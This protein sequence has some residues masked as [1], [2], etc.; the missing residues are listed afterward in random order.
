M[1]WGGVLFILFYL[2][3]LPLERDSLLEVNVYLYSCYVGQSPTPAYSFKVWK[4]L[5]EWNKLLV[6]YEQDS[7]SY[8][9][10][11]KNMSFTIKPNASFYNLITGKTIVEDGKNSYLTFKPIVDSSLY[12]SV[13]YTHEKKIINGFHTTKIRIRNKNNDHI[14]SVFV[15]PGVTG[16]LGINRVYGIKD[17][18]VQYL[19]V[20]KKDEIRIELKRN[21]KEMVKE[22]FFNVN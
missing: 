18:I 13:K 12:Y 10:D 1:N 16:V 19:D 2:L 9:S 15:V 11:G 5:G 4:G 14:D 17:L 6:K 21:Y 20:S 22:D 8:E 3:R 7:I